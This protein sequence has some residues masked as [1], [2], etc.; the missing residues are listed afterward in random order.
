M[1][2]QSAGIIRTIVQCTEVLELFGQSDQCKEV[3]E[4]FEQNDQCTEVLTAVGQLLVS[5]FIFVK[6]VTESY[7][8]HQK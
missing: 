4:L 6:K 5:S 7:N 1:S 8:K 3:L 2:V